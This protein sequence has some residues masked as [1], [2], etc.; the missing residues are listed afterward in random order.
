MKAALRSVL[1][2]DG[3]KVRAIRGTAL[4]VMGFGSS[5]LIRL[6]SNLILTRILFP[7]AFGLM[8]LV[9]VVIAGLEMFSDVAIGAS[10]VRSPRGDDPKYL[11]TAW[12]LQVIRGAVLWVVACLISNPI[13]AFYEQPE[14]GLIIPVL[15][16][17]TFIQGFQSTKMYLAN[18]HLT[19]GR[20]TAMELAS[21][22]SGTVFMIV[23]ALWLNSVWA[24]VM[25]ALVG[26][27]VR[28]V[29]SHTILPGPANRLAWERDAF[30]EIFHFGKYI[31]LGTAA[32]FF[33]QQGDRMVLG[34]YVSLEDLAVYTIAFMLAAVPLTLSTQLLERILF[35]L[36]R[37]RPPADNDANRKSIGR[38]RMLLTMGTLGMAAVLA[39]VGVL[40][41]T[42]LYD[43]RYH[44]AGPILVLLSLAMIPRQVIMSYDKILLAN[45]NSRDFTIFT[46]GT[47]I[48]RILVLLPMVS[49]FGL[50]GAALAPVIVD[51]F[52]YPF[53]V[54]FIRPY[55]GWYPKQDL[56][57]LIASCGIVMATIWMNPSVFDILP[58][59]GR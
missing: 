11:N 22:T 32:G 29:L 5:Q 26:V 30:R 3:L 41:V 57:F 10:V 13:A 43:P 54:Y 42:F 44:A 23:M 36:Y 46:T 59:A 34:K 33:V 48:A 31:I 55:S 21:Q 6:G 15:A 19:L 9:Q 45:G 7:E 16:M 58:F 4:S 40:A 20:L 24:L 8:A 25:G 38:A 47:A 51:I 14:L 2:G 12:T 50:I 49:K 52:S 18:R 35:P 1:S 17:S 39:M 28:V 27:S 56:A 37:T 53:L